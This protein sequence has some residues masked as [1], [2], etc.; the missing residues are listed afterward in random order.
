MKNVCIIGY[1][2]IGPY[3]AA[4][5]EATESARF[6]GICDINPQ[7]IEKCR[8]KYDVK[9]YTDFQDVLAD[10]NVHSV[11]ICTP[12]YL[13]YDMI[14]DALKAGKSVVA[15]KPVAMT[16]E[17]FDALLKTEGI[18]NVCLVFQNRYNPCVQKLK[19]LIEEQ[20]FGK[21]ICSR[22]VVTWNRNR[23]YYEQDQWRG[24]WATEG[25]GVLINQSIH[26]LDILIYL[27]GDIQSVQATMSNYTLSDV[28]EVEDTVSAHF[29]YQNGASGI[30]FAT[31]AYCSD[32]VP[33]IEFV[34]ENE[35]V[36]YMDSKLWIGKEVICRDL[37]ATGP[38]AC[39]GLGHSSLIR[40]YYDD[41]EYFNIYDAKN[42]METVFAM[43]ESAKKQNFG[44]SI[45]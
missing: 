27:G 7:R 39:Y 18:E 36:R 14:K 28:I 41:N 44:C 43:Y 35:T 13:H 15:E 6:Y 38:K 20:T 19:S 34:F 33:E 24:K 21:L 3:H 16:K 11:H 31:N 23:Q 2:S 30:F 25:G 8:T 5:L 29:C 4:A 10:E 45:V 26:T 12:H 1:G 40:R 17:Q 32:K 42:T 22:A 37:V 9:A